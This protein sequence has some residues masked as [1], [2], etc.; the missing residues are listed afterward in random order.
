VRVQLVDVEGV[1]S[2]VHVG[3]VRL[4]GLVLV[5]VIVAHQITV[6]LD[7]LR[8][9]ALLSVQLAAVNTMSHIDWLNEESALLVMPMVPMCVVRPS[10]AL[11]TDDGLACRIEPEIGLRHQLLVEG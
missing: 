9:V 3:I 7:C 6:D 5:V 1:S 10:C 8:T 4:R 11:L 2:L